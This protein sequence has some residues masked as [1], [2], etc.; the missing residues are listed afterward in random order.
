MSVLDE[1]AGFVIGLFRDLFECTGQRFGSPSLGVLGICDGNNGVQWN[2][3]YSQL[4]ECAFLGVNL[5]GLE[6][7]GWPVARLIER[8][9][10]RPRL[11]SEYRARVARPGRVDVSWKRDAWQASSRVRITERDIAPTPIALDRLDAAGWARALGGARECLD[12]RR[13]YR[14]RRRTRVTLLRSGRVVE[15]WVSPHLQFKT[16][17]YGFDSY[18][19]QQAR[20][21]LDG[22]HEFAVLQ[23]KVDAG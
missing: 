7:D 9:L 4:V 20:D 15:R 17:L 18:T 21:D 11:L 16:R 10:S 1:R 12:P 3:G 8:E 6:Y 23:S 19:M 2:A 14:G 13:K 22:L 5:E